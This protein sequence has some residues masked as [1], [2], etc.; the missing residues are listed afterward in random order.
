MKF[1]WQKNEMGWKCELPGEVTLFASPNQTTHF[2]AKPKRGTKWRAGASV[3]D[4]TTNIMSRFGQDIY[5]IQF[6]N[7]KDAMNRAELIY[8]AERAEV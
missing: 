6:D 1:D 5:N 3:W 4:V 2:G 7:A 8:L